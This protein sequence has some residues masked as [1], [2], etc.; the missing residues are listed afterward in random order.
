VSDRELFALG[1]ASNPNGN[2]TGAVA[3]DT[4]RGRAFSL[5]SNNG[6]LA[7]AVSKAVA[8]ATRVLGGGTV[9][10]SGPGIL[11]SATDVSGP[12]MDV[13]GAVSPY[14]NTGAAQL[15]FRVKR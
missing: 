3:F 5:S 1:T 8:G 2:G 9:S 11:Q 15:F 6:I 7:L 4:S 13:L 14:T 12:Y 10:W